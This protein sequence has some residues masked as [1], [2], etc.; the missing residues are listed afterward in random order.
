MAHPYVSV[1]LFAATSSYHPGLSFLQS[2]LFS[3]TLI[4]HSTTASQGL[5]SGH[6]Q[7]LRTKDLIFYSTMGHL[8]KKLASLLATFLAFSST[9]GTQKGKPFRL[10][11]AINPNFSFDFLHSNA[12]EIPRRTRME[13]G[14]T[15]RWRREGSA[16]LS[17]S[18]GVTARRIIFT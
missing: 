5:D 9:Q 2:L 3:V 16:W 1:I 4:L 7:T 6:Q 11:R 12:N 10:S 17:S 18:P 8:F 13:M 15:D 14:L